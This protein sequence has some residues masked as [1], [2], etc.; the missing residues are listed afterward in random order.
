VNIAVAKAIQHRRDLDAMAK[1]ALLMVNCHTEY[2][3]TRAQVAVAEVAD[4]MGVHRA[5]AWRALTRASS[6]GAL[7][8]EKRPDGDPVWDLGP[9]VPVALARR[10]CRASAT[11]PVAPAR[12]LKDLDLEDLEGAAARRR[13]PTAAAPVDEHRPA[14]PP[15]DPGCEVCGGTG[16]AEGD[17]DRDRMVRCRG[18][19]KARAM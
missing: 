16:W 3:S 1:L 17:G 15:H 10:P 11:T 5:T 8:V 13:H 14:P 18:P 19:W 9:L 12:R 6:S 2:P 4:D 7:T